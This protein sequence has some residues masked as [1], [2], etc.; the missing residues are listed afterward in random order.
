MGEARNSIYSK[1][2]SELN[3]FE[4]SLNDDA[5]EEFGKWKN[6][7]IENLDRG[8]KARFSRLKFYKR[9]ESNSI[10]FPF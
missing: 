3:E 7:I 4:Q 5:L 6:K 9:L 10:D 1:Y 2:L 8:Q